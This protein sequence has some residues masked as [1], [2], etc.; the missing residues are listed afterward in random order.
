MGGLCACA[1]VICDKIVWGGCE[2]CEGYGGRR[3]Y[4]ADERKI[5]M[6]LKKF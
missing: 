6:R 5:E 4:R 1:C 2:M 3:E